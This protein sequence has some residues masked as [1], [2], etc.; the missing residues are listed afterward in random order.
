MHVGDIRI[1]NHKLIYRQK[2]RRQT[3]PALY[4]A[5]T[6]HT[7]KDLYHAWSIAQ[8]EPTC[9]NVQ[10]FIRVLWF[11]CTFVGRPD[12]LTRIVEEL[13]RWLFVHDPDQV[14][15]AYASI[16]NLID[17]L[18][19]Q[20]SIISSVLLT[21]YPKPVYERWKTYIHEVHALQ[22]TEPF[23][24][25]PETIPPDVV[26][27]VCKQILDEPLLPLRQSE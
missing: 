16:P 18:D 23:P 24:Q 27:T 7:V 19:S 8:E 20:K 17:F 25:L 11:T 2:N 3:R 26:L 12:I 4:K 10:E 21:T 15:S 13:A 9:D 6:R 1:R 22:T 5:L 14:L